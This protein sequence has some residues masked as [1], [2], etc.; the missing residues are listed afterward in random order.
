MKYYKLRYRSTVV[1]IVDSEWMMK[2]LTEKVYPHL[3]LKV[4]EIEGNI[5]LLDE[6]EGNRPQYF[7]FKNYRKLYILVNVY[8][9]L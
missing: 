2:E 4:E 9:L 1:A 7:F 6:V 3:N 8:I 5:Y